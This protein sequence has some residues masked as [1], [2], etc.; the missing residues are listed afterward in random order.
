MQLTVLRETIKTSAAM[1]CNGIHISL[2]NAA[3]P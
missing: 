2:S 1:G 3:S